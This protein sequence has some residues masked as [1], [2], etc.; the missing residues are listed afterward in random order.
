MW[1]RLLF[2][3]LLRLVFVGFGLYLV[4]VFGFMY[5]VMFTGLLICEFVYFVFCGFD[6]F[7]GLLLFVCGLGDFV[8]FALFCF[9]S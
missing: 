9:V 8:C 3:L 2:A 1:L 5:F 6:L 7:A 4:G